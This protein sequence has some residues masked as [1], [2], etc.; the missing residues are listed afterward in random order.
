MTDVASDS[1]V[2]S[3]LDT[4]TAWLDWHLAFGGAPGIPP[5]VSIG[6]VHDQRLIW[7]RGFGHADAEKKVPATADTLYRVASISKLFT[8]TVIMQLRDAGKLRLDDPVTTH[9]PWFAIKSEHSGAPPITVRHLI[10]HTS[11]Y[12]AKP[13]F[14]TGWIRTSRTG[15]ACDRDLASKTRYLHP[16]CAGS[17]PTSRWRSPARSSRR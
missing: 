12:R 10:T 14:R 3:G 7:A 16:R 8:A 5:G 9:L 4:L 17:T 11:G 2:R 15:R 6:I 1:G 13:P